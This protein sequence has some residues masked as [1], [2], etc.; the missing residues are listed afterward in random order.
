MAKKNVTTD[1]VKKNQIN[2]RVS[3]YQAELGLYKASAALADDAET[4]A[5]GDVLSHLFNLH[6]LVMTADAGAEDGITELG[7]AISAY[8]KTNKI[9][10]KGSV[11]SKIMLIFHPKKSAPRRS[12]WAK[13]LYRAWCHGLPEVDDKKKIVI[14]RHRLPHAD[15]NPIEAKRGKNTPLLRSEEHPD[16]FAAFVAWVK[17]RGG[18]DGVACAATKGLYYTL[19]L[20]EQAAIDAAVAKTTAGNRKTEQDNAN[21]RRE[22]TAKLIAAS[23]IAKI[24]DAAVIRAFRYMLGEHALGKIQF[25]VIANFIGTGKSAT[26]T[27]D[28]LL[29]EKTTLMNAALD[30]IAIA[31]KITHKTKLTLPDETASSPGTS[32]DPNIVA[33]KQKLPRA[34]EHDADASAGELTDAV[35]A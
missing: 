16:A 2:A 27:I 4:R 33:V 8:A 15:P 32:D 7:K 35:A 20:D 5:E 11:F 34:T 22:T 26:L 21:T 12:V 31:E 9:T 30:D 14:G 24:T 10:L 19:T 23:P 25:V 3:Q 28:R 6:H 13:V 18:I 17:A 29:I 1:V